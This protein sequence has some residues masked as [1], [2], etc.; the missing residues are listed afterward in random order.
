MKTLKES[1]S[2]AM[3]V[4]DEELFPFLSYFLSDFWEMGSDPDTIIRIIKKHFPG[5]T[6]LKVADLG[7]GKGPVSVKIAR[8]LNY[9]CFG[10]DGVPE[11]IE[12]AIEKAKEYNVSALCKFRVGD[13]REVLQTLP[14]QDIIILGAVGPVFGDYYTTLEQLKTHLNEQGMI[15]LDEAYTGVDPDAAFPQVL[16]R[17]KLFGYFKSAGLKVIEEIIARED[18]KNITAYDTEFEKLKSRCA[19]LSNQYPEKAHLFS[20]YLENQAKQYKALK[21][22]VI[23]VTLAL[24]RK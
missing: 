18:E 13:L 3:G 17:E 21:S 24:V 6:D 2:E 19:E 22:S 11:F 14:A 7:C 1:I 9:T 5:K 16:A 8:E 20:K 4:F 23:G 10:V 15:I 12:T